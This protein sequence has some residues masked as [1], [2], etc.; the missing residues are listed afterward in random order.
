[1]YGRTDIEIIKYSIVSSKEDSEVKYSS[2]GHECINES[3]LGQS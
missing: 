1:M 2:E 3:H